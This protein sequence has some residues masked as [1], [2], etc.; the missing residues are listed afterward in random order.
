MLLLFDIAFSFWRTRF[1]VVSLRFQLTSKS[2]K[3]ISPTRAIVDFIF[4]SL[5]L[6]MFCLIY[7]GWRYY[8]AT[9]INVLKYLCHNTTIISSAS[10]I[11]II[12]NEPNY[13]GNIIIWKKKKWYEVHGQ[14]ASIRHH[15]HVV[16]VVVL[17]VRRILPAIT[18][19]KQ[20]E[21]VIILNK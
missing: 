12:K 11:S 16:L 14:M 13:D 18:E 20:R 4:C 9:L 8:Q 15:H 3:L 2:F 7:V 10:Q 1:N 19:Y 21:N 17:R 6:F 5:V